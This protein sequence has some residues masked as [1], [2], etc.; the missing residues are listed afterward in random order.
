MFVY[1]YIIYTP[2]LWSSRFLVTCL[3]HSYQDCEVPRC[4]HVLELQVLIRVRALLCLPTFSH[5]LI[6]NKLFSLS[7]FLS[8]F[9]LSCL[10]GLF[11]RFPSCCPPP[12]PPPPPP[13]TTTTT[14]TTP[15][16]PPPPP[17]AVPAV[18][19]TLQH[20]PTLRPQVIT[21]PQCPA[22]VVI[23]SCPPTSSVRRRR[24]SFHCG[25]QPGPRPSTLD[26]R[27]MNVDPKNATCRAGTEAMPW[28]WPSIIRP[29]S[30]TAVLPQ[31]RVSCSLG[32]WCLCVVL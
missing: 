24:P 10:F 5:F 15:P 13:P 8:F 26:I 14:T 1:I 16:P 28:P 20:A 21:V 2:F 18:P 19:S 12:P 9:S 32:R 27:G 6:V 3:A 22:R 11:S 23:F 25:S 29:H 30:L 31:S 7:P 4:S 17:L